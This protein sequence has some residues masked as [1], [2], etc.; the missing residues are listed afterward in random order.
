MNE[1]GHFNP[2]QTQVFSCLYEDEDEENVLVAAPSGSDK[3]VC[4]EFAILRMFKTKG[5]TAR[6]VYVSPKE[7]LARIR[8]ERWSEKFGAGLKR[9]VVMLTGKSQTDL[10]LLK[11]AHVV[12]CTPEQW[13][14]LSRQWRK[15]ADV[16][17]IS[18][19]LLDQLHLVGGRDGPTLEVI[20]SRM[21]YIASQVKHKIRIVALSASVANARTLGEWIGAKATTIFSFH[22]RVRELPTEIHIQGFSS[23]SFGSRMLAMSKPTYNSIMLHASQ[24][25]ENAVVFVPSRRQAQLTAIDIMAYAKAIHEEDQFL[26]NVN[27]VKDVIDTRLARS[28]K[29]LKI[30]LAQVVGFLHT[31]M[32]ARER[33][34]VKQLYKDGSIRV[35]VCQKD[36]CWSVSDVSARLVTVTGTCS[37]DA[38]EHRYV[39]Y[40]ITDVLQMI[41][42]A[43]RRGKDSVGNVVVLCHNPKKVYLKRF[44]HESLP[45]ESHFDLCVHDTMN[46]EIANRTLE[47]KQDAVDYLTWTFYYRRLTQNPN[48]YNMS[49]RGH[50]HVSDHLSELIE[51]TLGELIESKCI[52]CEDEM[53]L[54]PL[55][56]GMI[57]SYYSVRYTT[58]EIF[59]TSVQIGTKIR[60]MIK[61]LSAASEFDD[62]A[63]SVGVASSPLEM[64]IR[65]LPSKVD[66]EPQARKVN[67]LLQAHFERIKL[68]LDLREDQRVILKRCVKLLLAL[69]DVISSKGWL[70]P[71]L[72]CIELVQMVIQGRWSWDNALLQIPHFDKDIVD[73]IETYNKKVEDEDDKVE[74]VFDILELEDDVR[75][76]LLRLENR[77]MSDVARFC[78]SYPNIEMEYEVVKQEEEISTKSVVRMVVKLSRDEDDVPDDL[79]ELGKVVAPSFPDSNLVEGWWLVVGDSK[80]NTLLSIKRIPSLKVEAEV[81]LA[82]QAPKEAGDHK[83]SLFLMCDSYLRCDQ[84]YDFE[85][86]VVDGGDDSSSSSGSESEDDV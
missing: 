15:R 12:I 62:L 18:L 75:N 29:A 49:G 13:D 43:G 11:Q 10:K 72:A 76:D 20:V 27:R 26:H 53:T 45:V 79:S 71:A 22:P 40:P 61:I 16:R 58:I 85:L 56:L 9:K 33:S 57:A 1:S 59:A 64:M 25:D 84:Q 81:K 30:V 83:L 42:L 38:A 21:R 65:H 19:F 51:D 4:A 48:Y 32:T 3:I 47:N 50:E 67:A 80:T 70:K 6:C 66:G 41:G 82:F 54:S 68:S 24:H 78:N 77:Q 69:V 2:I 5:D 31:G 55:N 37:Y 39:D 86:S 36:L 8:Y 23:N 63:V 7:E 14:S 46:A 73:R 28:S 60:G 34:V 44:L 17:N 74:N 52:S 35:L